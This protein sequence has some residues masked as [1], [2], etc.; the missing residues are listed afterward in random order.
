MSKKYLILV[1]LIMASACAYTLEGQNQEITIRTPGAY[2]AVCDVYAN[3][4]RYKFYPPQ[5]RFVNKSEEDL[6]IDCKAPGNR[7]R[8]VVIEPVISKVAP[9]NAANGLVPGTM[10]DYASGALFTYPEVIEVDFTNMQVRGMEPPTHNNPDIKQP[11]EYTLE[12]FKA[13]SPRMN[14]DRYEQ[15]I[16]LK[17]RRPGGG[18]DDMSYNNDDNYSGGYIA[19]PENGAVNS[20]KGDLMRVIDNLGDNLDP[21][22]ET[23]EIVPGE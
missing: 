8:K 9:A 6:I 20:D 14:S 21:S 22:G 5:T 12:E 4:I 15:E 3:K 2:D 19:V 11:E 10:W 13:G 1:P 17:R 18:F 23:G 16:P 7:N